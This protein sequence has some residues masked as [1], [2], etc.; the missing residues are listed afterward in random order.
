MWFQIW[1]SI[2]RE[3]SQVC[4]VTRGCS[5]PLALPNAADLTLLQVPAVCHPTPGSDCTSSEKLLKKSLCREKVQSVMWDKKGKTAVRS[6]EMWV[7]S[8]SRI[9]NEKN[10]A[11]KR[12][13]ILGEETGDWKMVTRP[14]SSHSRD[15]RDFPLH[16]W[17]L[18]GQRRLA[19]SEET[20]LQERHLQSLP[21]LRPLRCQLWKTSPFSH[22]LGSSMPAGL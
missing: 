5:L 1:D 11:M 2:R 16:D 6:F 9:Q 15:C 8:S 3:Y 4:P 7:V 13:K 17:Q 18:P 22:W 21:T 10:T 12:C 20:Q 19:T 14:W